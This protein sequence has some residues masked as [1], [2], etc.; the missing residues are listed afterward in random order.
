R[1]KV[2]DRPKSLSL[3]EIEKLI[4]DPY[5]IYA[6]HLLQLRPLMPL[7]PMADARLRGE[8]LHKV[9]EALLREGLP[10]TPEEAAA[11]LM[12]ITDRVLEEDVAWPAMRAIWRARMAE[13]ALPFVQGLLAEGGEVVSLEQKY[14]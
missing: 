5:A 8:I 11:A 14:R 10:P 6:R 9:P 4:R 7:R 1:P 3:T 2:A 12:R 13:L